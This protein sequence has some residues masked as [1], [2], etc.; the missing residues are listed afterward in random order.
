MPKDITYLKNGTGLIVCDG[1]D[2]LMK[3]VNQQ[4]RQTQSAIIEGQSAGA[5]AT[6]AFKEA[7]RATQNL[8]SIKAHVDALIENLIK[9]I[10]SAEHMEVDADQ[11]DHAGITGYYQLPPTQPMGDV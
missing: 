5:G 10:D 6:L 11:L 2:T 7:Q 4:A 9:L 1:L 8:N 3:I